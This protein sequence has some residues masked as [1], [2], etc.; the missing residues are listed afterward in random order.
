MALP[1][2]ASDRKCLPR[3]RHRDHCQRP[4]L[5][6]SSAPMASR[7]HQPTGPL[8]LCIRLCLCHGYFNEKPQAESGPLQKEIKRQEKKTMRNV[9]TIKTMP[10]S[11]SLFSVPDGWECKQWSRACTL[12][13][14]L[15]FHV[16]SQYAVG[17][18][19]EVPGEYADSSGSTG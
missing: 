6:P 10:A 8:S 17:T 3:A 7:K 14:P 5:S 13:D 12:I 18:L 15:I 4:G 16:I 9:T 1:V 19:D 11:P 2:I